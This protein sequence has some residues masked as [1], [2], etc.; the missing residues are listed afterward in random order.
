MLRRPLRR[1]LSSYRSLD[2][3]W[4]CRL[5]TRLTLL[6]CIIHTVYASMNYF[7][8][9]VRR[10]CCSLLNSLAVFIANVPSQCRPSRSFIWSSKNIDL[11]FIYVTRSSVC[12]FVQQQVDVPVWMWRSPTLQKVICDSHK[13][14]CYH[15]KIIL[16]LFTY[17]KCLL[18]SQ[19]NFVNVILLQ[20]QN[21]FCKTNKAFWLYLT[22]YFV[23]N[24][25][26]FGAAY[27]TT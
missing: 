8:E 16:W 19:K 15:Y 14:F 4:R 18:L 25:N 12:K 6:W 27:K 17:K 21:L 11:R 13:N 3:C 20:S 9:L 26:Q 2:T 10:L 5:Q 7:C 24:T 1:L 22:K 23:K